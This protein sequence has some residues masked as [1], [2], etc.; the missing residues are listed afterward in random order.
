MMKDNGHGVLNDWDQAKRV[1]DM[2]NSPQHMFRTV[3]KSLPL[4]EY[5]ANS[6]FLDI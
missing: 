5:C 4:F 1:A 3:S 6:N 2:A